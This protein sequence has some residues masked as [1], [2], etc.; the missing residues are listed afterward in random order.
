[1]LVLAG[2]ATG[3][4]FTAHGWYTHTLSALTVYYRT[5]HTRKLAVAAATAASSVSK[6]WQ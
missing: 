1:V 6:H 2:A 3:T 5:Y 4:A